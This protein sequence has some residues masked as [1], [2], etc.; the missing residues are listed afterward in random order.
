VSVA[1]VAVV[2]RN[3]APVATPA[4]LARLLRFMALIKGGIAVAAL[5]AVW[6]RLRVPVTMKLSLAYVV[7]TW[8]MLGASVAIWQ[9]AHMVLAAVAFHAGMLAVLVAAWRD[10]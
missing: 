1:L 5:G 7:G 6:W 3:A 4:D 8:I 10:M 9:L 2:S